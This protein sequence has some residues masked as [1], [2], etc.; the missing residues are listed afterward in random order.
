MATT[1]PN[2]IKPG[3]LMAVIHYVKVKSVNAS[4]YQFL[5]DD[6][7]QDTRGMKVCG[8]DLLE[9]A[10]SADQYTEEK[11][12]GKIEAA[13][14]LVA[15]VNRPFT[16][17]FEKS[18]G[19]E[20]VLRGRLIKPEPLL[21]RSMVEDLDEPANNRVRQVDHRTIKWL[22]VENVKYVVK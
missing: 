17:A 2:K 16:V 13:E 21:G 7:D 5:A 9:R 12:V 15:S 8:K 20:R 3:D 1:D 19:K 10:Y 4:I 22:I 11:K 6:V 14:T 18:D